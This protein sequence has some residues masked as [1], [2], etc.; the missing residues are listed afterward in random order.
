MYFQLLLHIQTITINEAIYKRV[1]RLHL[2]YH[3]DQLAQIW[4]YALTL[5]DMLLKNYVYLREATTKNF[6]TIKLLNILTCPTGYE[7]LHEPYA[8]PPKIY[9]CDYCHGDFHHLIPC[10]LR[11]ILGL[12]LKMPKARPAESRKKSRK[13]RL[14]T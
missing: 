9:N 10:R 4:L 13:S 6:M 1:G 14:V 7:D 5:S 12:R 8:N 2:K 3:T 11:L